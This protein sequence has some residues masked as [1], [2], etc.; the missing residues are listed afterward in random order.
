MYQIINVLFGIAFGLMVIALAVCHIAERIANKG[1]KEALARAER[2][3]GER[4]EW[5]ECAELW[6]EDANRADARI[7]ELEA[8]NEQLREPDTSREEVAELERRVEFYISLY[9]FCKE[10]CERWQALYDERIEYAKKKL[11]TAEKRAEHWEEEYE[12]LSVEFAY[13]CHIAQQHGIDPYKK[14]EE[15]A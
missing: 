2:L 6:A 12:K 5:K 13:V 3:R 9:N 4:D 7:R 8:E 14:E 10:M 15:E 1:F 11:E